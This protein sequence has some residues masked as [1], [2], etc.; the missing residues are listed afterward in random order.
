VLLHGNVVSLTSKEFE[1]LALMA[2]RPGDV[3]TREEILDFL[4]G[5]DNSKDIN[6]ITVF[7]RRIREKIEDNPSNPRYILTVRSAGYKFTMH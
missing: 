5:E 4:W 7:I 6:T 2:S 1:I 3:F